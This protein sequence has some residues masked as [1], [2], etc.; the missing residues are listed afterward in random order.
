MT[1]P[2]PEL[3]VSDNL[4]ISKLARYMR[5]FTS[6]FCEV[7]AIFKVRMSAAARAAASI[8]ENSSKAPVRR[9]P[10]AEAVT[11]L[12]TGEASIPLSSNVKSLRI[13]Y[14]PKSFEGTRYAV[15]S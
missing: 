7:K 14:V 1:R 2:L 11:L 5:E 13:Q 8:A 3:G 10:I 15:S 12:R 9:L 6:H 4:P